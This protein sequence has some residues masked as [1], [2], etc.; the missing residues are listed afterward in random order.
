M[1]RGYFN[2]FQA[3]LLYDSLNQIF[4]KE[5]FRFQNSPYIC[6]LKKITLCQVII[7][8]QPSRGKKAR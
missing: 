7:N 5:F 2:K 1:R 8:G 4:I 3:Y 6:H